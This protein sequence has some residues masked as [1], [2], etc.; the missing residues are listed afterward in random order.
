MQTGV[1]SKNY[2][3]GY[4]LA[5]IKGIILA[6]LICGYINIINLVINQSKVELRYIFK[7]FT[8]PQIYFKIVTI[9]CV[10]MIV[11][12]TLNNITDYLKSFIVIDSLK[13]VV[14]I[15]LVCIVL[16]VHILLFATNY[17]IVMVP[18]MSLYKVF[19]SS[20]NLMLKNFMAFILLQISFLGW[21]LLGLIIYLLVTIVFGIQYDSINSFI[22]IGLYES[23]FFGIGVYFYPYYDTT[24]VK[25]ASKIIN[26]K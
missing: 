3:N 9:N 8:K 25:F 18:N 15:L 16:I 13:K 19:K 14:V 26:D 24:M 11:N 10:I 22:I 2:L 12:A 7:Y 1:I 5:I 23:F 17:I 21:E 6:P 20:I 4:I